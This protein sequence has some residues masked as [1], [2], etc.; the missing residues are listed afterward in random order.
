MER[1]DDRLRAD[2]FYDPLHGRIYEAAS[3]LIISGAL[4]D[5]VVLKT[6][7]ERD[8]GMKEVGGAVYLADLMREAPEPASV[9][10]AQLASRMRTAFADT[11]SLLPGWLGSCSAKPGSGRSSKDH[12]QHG[13]PSS[14]PFVR[15][16]PSLSV[17]QSSLVHL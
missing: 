10:A 2:H 3:Q 12:T 4:A 11:E 17:S 7:F 13:S 1:I 6:R 5:A 16:S 14:S 15:P 8:P 9:A